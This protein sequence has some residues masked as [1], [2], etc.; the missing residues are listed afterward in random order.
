LLTAVAASA[1]TLFVARMLAAIGTTGALT[2][3]LSLGADLC[4]PQER[5]RATLIITLGKTLGTAAAFTLSGWLFGLFGP[6]FAA[7]LFGGIA[8]WRATHYALAILGAV[9][10]LP[11]FFLR[12]PQRHEVLAGNHAP[13]RVVAGELWSRRRFLVPLFAGQVGVVMADAAAGIW[14]APVLSRGYGLSPEQFAGWMGL[15]LLLTGIFGAIVGGFA[16]DAGVKSG[17]RGGL[18]IG[19]VIA[20]LVSIPAAL[21]PVAPG[22]T[23]FAVALGTLMLCG[24]VTGLV[25]SVAL[26]TLLPNELRGLCIGAFIAIAG[27]IGYGLTP[28]LVAWVSSLLGG[29]AAI[30]SA[31]AIVGTIVSVLA[32]LA[33]LLAMYRAPLTA[34][35]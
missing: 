7:D 34:T 20:A 32:F 29:E 17:R 4:L 33:F 5:G 9:F 31:L 35:V 6:G 18:L 11:L 23:S 3:A 13:F 19:A 24:T 12:E 15:L 14:A 22:V 1:T 21:F 10:A 27:L 8:P 26:T 2:C 16:A 25:T 30:G 28:T